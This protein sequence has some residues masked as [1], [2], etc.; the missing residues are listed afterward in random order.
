MRSCDLNGD[1]DLRGS[2]QIPASAAG[3]SCAETSATNA[4]NGVAYHHPPRPPRPN[5]HSARSTTA[6]TSRG[7]LPWRLSDAGPTLGVR[8]HLRHRPASETLHKTGRER[9]QQKRSYSITSS[10]RIRNASGIS[11]LIALAALRLITSSKRVGTS[12]GRLPGFSP[13]RM[14]FSTRVANR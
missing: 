13:F 8:G 14:I 11:R 1:I 9:S 5:P 6:A 10:A 4:F 3:Q 12:I 2:R 7:F